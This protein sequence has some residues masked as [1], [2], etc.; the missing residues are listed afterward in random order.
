M[1][2]AELPGPFAKPRQP[3]ENVIFKNC[4]GRER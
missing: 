3:G 2:A 4:N 1:A